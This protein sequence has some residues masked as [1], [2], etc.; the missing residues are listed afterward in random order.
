VEH[1]L[2]DLLTVVRAVHFAS[3]V[4]VAGAVLFECFVADTAFR[5]AARPPLRVALSFRARLSVLLLVSLLLT[6]VSGAGWLL[7]LAARIGDQSVS[8]A[9]T[10]GTAWLLFTQTRF[11]SDWE[12]RLLLAT[13]L[14]ARELFGPRPFSRWSDLFAASVGIILVA[15]L[16]WAGHG[17]ATPGSAGYAHLIAD[18]FHLI[19][20]GAWIG[21]LVP[22]VLL[23]GLLRRSD[24][25]GWV[26]IA[27]DVTRRFSN[28]GILAVGTL[29]VSGV[30]NASFLAGGFQGLVGT[31]YGR[32]LLL[33]IAL[34]GSMVC[35]ASVNRQY[36]LPRLSRSLGDGENAGAPTAQM[37]EL[38]AVAEIILGLGVL[39]IVGML[40]I[41][42]P[43]ANLH[44]HVH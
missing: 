21:G 39:I 12:L 30:T 27:G 18:I 11:G 1:D 17:A 13:L 40:G 32:L 25:P 42:Q 22:L 31:Y 43:S 14:A 41:A 16:A 3:T 20:A 2:I 38:S 36:L 6:V 15:S 33:K 7:L 24:A 37:L 19:A 4:S 9:I 23:L 10:G 34:F 5:L 29:L 8:E 28:L 26:T 44:A 35:L